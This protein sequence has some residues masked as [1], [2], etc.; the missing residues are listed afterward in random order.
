MA[1][2]LIF[3]WVSP[4]ATVGGDITS[5]LITGNAK[6]N[7]LTGRIQPYVILGIGMMILVE[8]LGAAGSGTSVPP[9][10]RFGIGVDFYIDEHLL[11]NFEGVYAP[12]LDNRIDDFPYGMLQGNLMYR[13]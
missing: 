1:G 2:E 12:P 4:W 9:G 11:V 6:F 5:Y 13:F 10:G 7:V 8:D 3:D